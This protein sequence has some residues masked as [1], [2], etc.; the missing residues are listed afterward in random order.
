MPPPLVRRPGPSQGL[1][2]TPAVKTFR[3]AE[4][5]LL[6]VEELGERTEQDPGYQNLGS[7]GNLI[8][9][10]KS[11]FISLQAYLYAQDL[12][13]DCH[14]GL[15][16]AVFNCSDQLGYRILSKYPVVL[17]RPNINKIYKRSTANARAT[18]TLLHIAAARQQH[19]VIR[20]LRDLGA[21]YQEVKSFHLVLPQKFRDLLDKETALSNHLY[22]L[23]WNPALAPLIQQDVETFDLLDEFWDAAYV[24]TFNLAVA[25]AS[26]GV[27]PPDPPFWSMTVH[28]LAASLTDQQYSVKLLRHAVKTHPSLNETPGGL[29]RYSV[30]HFAIQAF[31]LKALRYLLESGIGFGPYMVD[32]LGNNPL[33]CVFRLALESA[34]NG[35]LRTV[36]KRMAD[37][38]MDNHGFHHRMV[39]TYWPYESPVLILAQSA[40]IDWSGRQHVIKYLLEKCLKGEMDMKFHR[41]YDPTVHQNTL[42]IPD[43]CGNTALAF[44]AKAIVAHGGNAAM[45]ALFNKMIRHGAKLNLDI[46]PR[47]RPRKYAHSIKYIVQAAEGCTRFKKQV[48]RLGGSLHQAEIDGTAA[49]YN[50]IDQRDHVP[51]LHSLPSHHLFFQGHP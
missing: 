24:G 40:L 25:F 17:L 35:T 13:D 18:F 41:N 27:A 10:N 46:N 51:H 6:I 8:L 15:Q 20:K 49:G 30:L 9:T 36:C 22:R 44:M 21:K 45:E 23:R 29:E 32:S 28:H 2:N 37:D 3:I 26:H 16:H 33:H 43:A 42:N 48:D 19:R 11:L 1:V 38:L 39:R 34:N 5:L 14:K 47:Y 4:L 7:L 31:N 12:E 50:G